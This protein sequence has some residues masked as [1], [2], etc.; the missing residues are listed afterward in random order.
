MELKMK[1]IGKWNLSQCGSCWRRFR[2]NDTKKNLAATKVDAANDQQ[3]RLQGHTQRDTQA[4]TKIF[5]QKKKKPTSRVV[6][7][8]I[9]FKRT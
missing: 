6:D 1:Q 7:A 2:F 9:I 8:K 4:H 3:V 5:G